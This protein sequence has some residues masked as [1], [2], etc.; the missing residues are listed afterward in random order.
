MYSF[1]SGGF[2]IIQVLTVEICPG[3]ARDKLKNSVR[4]IGLKGWWPRASAQT[5][6][7]LEVVPKRGCSGASAV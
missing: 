7:W 4:T 3:R 5:G 6:A 1:L 2:H